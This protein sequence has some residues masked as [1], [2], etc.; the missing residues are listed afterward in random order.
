V[1]NLFT[2]NVNR[3]PILDS[4]MSQM[5]KLVQDF[6]ANG[7]ADYSVIFFLIFSAMFS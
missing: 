2:G 1:I 3:T 5:A 7:H 4:R 6:K